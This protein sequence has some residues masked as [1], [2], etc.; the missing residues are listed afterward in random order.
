MR[1]ASEVVSH[2]AACVDRADT[3]SD[4]PA[5]PLDRVES[6]GHTSRH[7]WRRCRPCCVAPTAARTARSSSLRPSATVA[8]CARGSS[9]APHAPV[10]SH[11]RWHRRSHADPPDFV[12]RESAGLARFAEEMRADGWDRSVPRP[13]QCDLPYWQ[14]QA[15]S[16]GG[17]SSTGRVRPGRASRWMLARTPAGRATSSPLADSRWSRWTSARHDLQGLR[18]AEHFLDRAEVFFERMRSVMFVRPWR[19]K[20]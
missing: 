4:F 11:H 8:R 14:G 17:P 19:A 13:T 10:D 9:P 5:C 18:A 20:A 15:A 16:D 12:R 3:I 2:D 7:A 1:S 6:S